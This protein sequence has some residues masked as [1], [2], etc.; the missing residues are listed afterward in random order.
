M[1][2]VIRSA[3]PIW[4]SK[5]SPIRTPENRL[6]SILWAPFPPIEE[7]SEKEKEEEKTD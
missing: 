4:S 5:Q 3:I 7:E 6:L 1:P 2:G